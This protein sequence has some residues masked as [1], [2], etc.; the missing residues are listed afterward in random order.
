MNAAVARA[1]AVQSGGGDLFAVEGILPEMS[2]EAES[3]KKAATL[4]IFSQ[5]NWLPRRYPI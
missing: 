5:R 4:A 2:R 3:R 1:F